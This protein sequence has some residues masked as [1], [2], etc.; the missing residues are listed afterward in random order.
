MLDGPYRRRRGR[1]IDP[2]RSAPEAILWLIGLGGI[3]LGLWVLILW[4]F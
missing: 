2:K 4:L 3:G 1:W